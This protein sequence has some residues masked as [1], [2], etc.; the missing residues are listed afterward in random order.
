MPPSVG[1]SE[2]QSESQFAVSESAPLRAAA[3]S[4]VAS[5]WVWLWPSLPLSQLAVTESMPAGACDSYQASGRAT[6]AEK[7]K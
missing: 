2:G 1:D 6:L 4:W 7:Q 5:S 3:S